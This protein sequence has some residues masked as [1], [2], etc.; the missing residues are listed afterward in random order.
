M[1]VNVCWLANIHVWRYIEGY[2]LGSSIRFQECPPCHD[3]LNWKVWL[4]GSLNLYWKFEA[5]LL[6]VGSGSCSIQ[7]IA[8]LWSLL[9]LHVRG[10]YDRSPD[11]F[12]FI[13]ALLLIVHTWNSSPL[14]SN[15]RRKQCTCCTVPTFS[16]RPHGRPLVWACQWASSQSLSSPQLSHNDSLWT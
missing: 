13:W 5:V 8:F 10:L 2:H 9:F 6:G 12:F 7:D 3:R 11:V 15:L 4:I 14:R 16:A 1:N